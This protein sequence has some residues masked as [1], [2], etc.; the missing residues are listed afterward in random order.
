[1]GSFNP[2]CWNSYAEWCQSRGTVTAS[3]LPL[4]S[5]DLSM[6]KHITK[7]CVPIKEGPGLFKGIL[8]Y[9]NYSSSDDHYCF[10]AILTEW[11]EA[12]ETIQKIGHMH[13]TEQTQI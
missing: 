12:G 11:W 13:Y 8:A 3:F 10:P 7:M 4:L 2:E 5:E 6:R 1:M 9:D